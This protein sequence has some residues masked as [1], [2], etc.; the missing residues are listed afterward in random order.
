MAGG[1]WRLA[2]EG[3]WLRNCTFTFRYQEV[4]CTYF[5]G[6]AGAAF[7]LE[8]FTLTPFPI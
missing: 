3:R 5:R 8:R 4:N 7:R 2:L 1:K 6:S